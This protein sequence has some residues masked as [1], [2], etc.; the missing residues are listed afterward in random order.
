[1]YLKTITYICASLMIVHLQSQAL[2][3]EEQYIEQKQYQK[4]YLEVESKEIDTAGLKDYHQKATDLVK[5][6]FDLLGHL[7]VGLDNEIQNDIVL[8][9]QNIVDTQ[10]IHLVLFN[11]D[12]KTCTWQELKHAQ[13]N[14]TPTLQWT[15]CSNSIP[16]NIEGL[17]RGKYSCKAKDQKQNNFDVYVSYFI[18]KYTK[19][20]GTQQVD[21]WQVIL[22]SIKIKPS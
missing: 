17:Y 11:E 19:N 13:S 9:L 5:Q 12:F 22:Q 21:S 2:Y 4:M 14:N 18:K 20:I 8:Q 15:D 6:Y 7:K 1:M 3:S 10:S 16:T